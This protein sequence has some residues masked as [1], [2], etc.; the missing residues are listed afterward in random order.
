VGDLDFRLQ[1]TDRKLFVGLGELLWDMLPAGK[2]LGGAP[3][4]FAYHAGQLGNQG[5]IA[6]RIG[7]DELGEETLA[8]LQQNHLPGCYVQRDEVY[9]TGTVE[10]RID[11]QGQPSFIVNE[12]V[13]W[14]FLEFTPDWQTLAARAD[15]VCFGSLAQRSAAAH[16]TIQSF[17][18][19]CRPE[20]LKIFDVNLRQAFFSRAVI[21]KSLELANLVKVNDQEFN[22]LTVLLSLKE[23]SDIKN[24]RRLLELYHLDM[25]CI[26][27]GACGSLLVDHQDFFEHDGMPVKVCDAIGAGDAFTAAMA[28]HY[29]RG[30]GLQKIS[31]AANRLGSWVAT[32]AGATPE[33]DQAVLWEVMQ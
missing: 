21:S 30:A 29:L 27:R 11:A 9:P 32:Q 5:I 20:G 4:N 16:L 19:G 15:A 26:T 14:D 24:A 2:Q 17:L 25:I 33:V 7:N 22:R 1:T 8:R 13:A 12:N 28:H 3:A 23:T 10:V 18:K 31:E 6:S